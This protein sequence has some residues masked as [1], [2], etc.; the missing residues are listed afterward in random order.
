MSEFRVVLITDSEDN[1]DWTDI[2]V[3]A[4]SEAEAKRVAEDTYPGF[5][6]DGVW[7]ND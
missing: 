5:I 2:V 6:A 1:Q 7:P 3:E 4:D